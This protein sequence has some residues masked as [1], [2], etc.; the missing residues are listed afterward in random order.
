VLRKITELDAAAERANLARFAAA[1]RR[2]GCGLALSGFGRE[3][4]SFDSLREFQTDS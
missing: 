2:L 3:N 4:V 1:V